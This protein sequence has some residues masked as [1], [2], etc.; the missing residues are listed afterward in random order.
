MK[1]LFFTLGVAALL[2]KAGTLPKVFANIARPNPK[3]LALI[4]KNK[5]P[6]HSTSHIKGSIILRI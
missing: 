2:R 4:K 5:L 6:R 3:K 1:L